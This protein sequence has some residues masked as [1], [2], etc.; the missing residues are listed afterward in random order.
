MKDLDPASAELPLEADVFMRR[1][2]RELTETLEDVVGAESAAGYINTVGSA[3]GRW[4]LSQYREAMDFDRLDPRQVAQVLV[5]LKRRI[6][7]DFF[8]IEVTEDRIVVGNRRCPFGEMA[9]GQPALCMMTSNVF[10]RVTADNL[11]YARVDLQET[12]AKG[13]QACRIVVYLDPDRD[14]PR[15]EREY[16]ATRLPEGAARPDP[17][18]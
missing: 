6:G 9:A 16:W 12:I 3:M 11:G 13:A 18:R 4:I 14:A 17:V 5:D 15:D 1:L 2:L 8:I 10:G 7:G